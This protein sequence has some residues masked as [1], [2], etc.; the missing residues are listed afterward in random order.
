VSFYRSRY[1]QLMSS[2]STCRTEV[3]AMFQTCST[4]PKWQ[5]RGR[6]VELSLDVVE[7]GSRDIL[8]SKDRS[9]LTSS[10]L[11]VPGGCS[12]QWTWLDILG[13]TG[14][15]NAA[16]SHNSLHPVG[17]E[18]PHGFSPLNQLSPPL[19]LTTISPERLCSLRA[20]AYIL[21]VVWL[22]YLI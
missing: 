10:A 13:N 9:L 16:P 3:R 8:R 19:S 5:T 1:T 14:V 18:F 22:I 15:A 2:L 20:P 21:I 4:I 12:T 7:A 11:A 6:P 17:S